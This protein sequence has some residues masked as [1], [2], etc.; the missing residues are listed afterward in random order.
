MYENLSECPLCNDSRISNFIICKDYT[1]SGESFA[2]VECKNCNFRFTSPRPTIE[3]IEK[4]YESEDYISHTNSNKRLINSIYRIVRNY[5]LFE[6]QS[7][8]TKLKPEKGNLLDYGCGTGNFL[9][10]C[11]K[12]NWKTYGIESNTKAKKI[13]ISQNLIIFNNIDELTKEVKEKFD[14]ITLWHV[15]EHLYNP[16]ETIRNLKKILNKEGYF[17][18]AIPNNESYD[19]TWYKEYWAAYDVPRHLSHFNQKTFKDFIVKSKLKIDRVIPMKL[20]AYYVSL[21][22]EKYKTSSNNYLKAMLLGKKSNEI[23]KEKNNYSSLIY[24]V[25]K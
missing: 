12:Q 16:E 6:K 18:I 25:K 3:N 1:V 10:Y 15:L 20:D 21:L 7:I 19:A 2:I 11:K 23:A 8:I 9:I 14:I 4:Y 17:L 22:S 5:T 13:A 24:V